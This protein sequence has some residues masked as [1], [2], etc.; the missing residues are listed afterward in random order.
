MEME[1]ITIG[2]KPAS[3]SREFWSRIS[4]ANRGIYLPYT[5]VGLA[6]NQPRKEVAFRLTA[7]DPPVM[8]KTFFW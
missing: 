5:R 2:R 1:S 6:Y 7:Y 3:T 4:V 8:W